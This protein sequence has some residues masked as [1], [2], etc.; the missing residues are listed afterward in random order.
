MRNVLL[1]YQCFR[2]PSPFQGDRVQIMVLRVSLLLFNDRYLNISSLKAFKDPV[3]RHTVGVI[4]YLSGSQ[5]LI[6]FL[7]VKRHELGIF[8]LF[9]SQ[10]TQG[11]T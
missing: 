5:R 1:S 10:G 8:D 4:V 6:V 11:L 7:F 3:L 9:P 2:L